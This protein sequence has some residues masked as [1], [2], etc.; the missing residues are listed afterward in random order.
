[1]DDQ[2]PQAADDAADESPDGADTQELPAVTD[3]AE[4]QPTA[5][6]TQEPE[7]EPESE[8]ESVHE[9][10]LEPQ[11]E[12]ADEAPGNTQPTQE[13]A[14][15]A[16]PVVIKKGGGMAS[17]AL[18]L[19][20]GA[21]GLSGYQWYQG[22]SAAAPAEQAELPDYSGLIAQRS[23]EVENRLTTRVEQL[24]SQLASQERQLGTRMDGQGDELESRVE[25]ALSELRKSLGEARSAM[26]QDLDE[27]KRQNQRL[28]AD[29]EGLDAT[30]AGIEE[31]SRRS[32]SAI[33]RRLG[34]VESS[35][36]ALADTRGDAASQLA[37]AETEY[38][39]RAATERLSL[40]ADAEGASRA[41]AL[42]A[43]QLSSVDDPIYSTV[44]QALAE[45]RQ[46]L[47]QLELP[48]RVALSTELLALARSSAEWPLDA[49]RSLNT[50]GANLLVPETTEE[51]WW[52]R[53]KSVLSN[54]VVVHREKETATVLLTLEEERLLREN[55]R[56]QLQVAQ[57]AAARG[58]QALF[59]SSVAAV[60]DWIT[61]Y[62]QTTAEPGADALTRLAALAG[63]RLS[64]ELPDISG[65]LRQL[66][67][68]RAT[69]D[70]A[71]RAAPVGGAEGP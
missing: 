30:L 21:A 3:A 38:L 59:E 24:E 23:Q 60:H 36:G 50:S 66:R 9:S 39:L 17:L 2:K 13:V 10:T 42:A 19:A 62:Y 4:E 1:M 67:S 25:S 15:E 7:P 8:P 26:E 32:A 47:S 70:L 69:E 40:F 20:L 56:L 34:H 63:T 48:D 5:E 54:V 37:L 45:H 6:V 18:L 16:A 43:E 22:Y 65:A 44:R 57:L 46:A 41:L 53:F 27:V 28:R 51:G 12:T 29:R 71:D 58:E 33:E 64:P 14:T 11:A 31:S 61:E 35:M 55:I 49:R 52:A 68:I